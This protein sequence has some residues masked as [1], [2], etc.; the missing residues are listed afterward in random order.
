MDPQLKFLSD[1]A[2]R[3]IT[4]LS[5]RQRNRM[6][7]DGKFPQPVTL[8]DGSGDRPGRVAWVEREI[9]E[10]VAERIA[11]RDRTKPM[12]GAATNSAPAATSSAS[13]AGGGTA[14]EKKLRLPLAD[15]GLPARARNALVA[16][17]LIH[18]GDL[19]Q[20]SEADVMGIP[21]ISR[22]SLAQIKAALS[23]HKLKLEPKAAGDR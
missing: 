1:P 21:N 15:L 2:C 8:T 10:W 11:E 14:L 5:R 23:R 12:N 16:D 9:R 13:K 17:G 19:V 20:R 22:V 3:D 18:V 4:Q 7:A 6:A